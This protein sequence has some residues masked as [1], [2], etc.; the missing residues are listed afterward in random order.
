MNAQV[1]ALVLAGGRGQRM[2]GRDKGLQVWAG[3]PLL[4]HALDRLRAQTRP[5]HALA[6]NAN[7]HLA[8][9]QALGLPVWPDVWPD[10][11]GPL[12]GMLTGLTHARTPWLLTVPCDS[13]RFPLD[14]LARLQ[15]ACHQHQAPMALAATPRPDGALRPESVF[16][17]LHRD[18]APTLQQYLQA[19]GRK[20][21]TW[22]MAQG[23]CLVGFDQA[24]DDPQAFVNLNTLAEL[25]ALAADGIQPS[26]DPS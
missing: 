17:L 26:Q 11:A 4:L 22:A 23:A 2:Q 1:T 21:E 20:I 7:R 9:Y 24:H 6:I 13:P 5:P 18:L 8:D 15:D 16:A 14:L 10:F 19:G 12:A 25:H 3:R